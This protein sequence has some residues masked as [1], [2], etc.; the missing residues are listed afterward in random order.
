MSA[1]QTPDHVR[2][3]SSLFY[4]TWQRVLLAGLACVLA[5]VLL[6][7]FFVGFPGGDPPLPLSDE[8]ASP[9][10][11]PAGDVLVRRYAP[12]GEGA[13]PASRGSA[14]GGVLAGFFA[15]RGGGGLRAAGA[16]A[17]GAGG[18]VVPAFCD[19]PHRVYYLDEW[20]LAVL[21]SAEYPRAAGGG[22]A[23]C[24]WRERTVCE[25]PFRMCTYARDVDT[26]ISKAVQVDGWWNAAKLRQLEKALPLLTAGGGDAPEKAAPRGSPG[27]APAPA[28]TLFID[29]GANIGFYSLMAAARGYDVLAVEPSAASLQRL[30][31]SVE[32][33]PGLTAAASGSDLA[34]EAPGAARGR[35]GG[36]GGSGGGGDVRAAT[37]LAM[38]N[39]AADVYGS[40]FLHYVADNP[41]ASFVNGEATPLAVTTVF[42]DDLLADGFRDASAGRARPAA[43]AAPAIDPRSVRAVKISAEAMDARVLH[44]ARRLLGLGE[45]P[46]VILVYNADHVARAGCKPT[47]LARAMF[48]AGYRLRHAGV[49]I[50]RELEL[51]RFLKKVSG[52]STELVFVRH[53]GNGR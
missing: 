40:A 14:G 15:R 2:C 37:V 6:T 31:L 10:A 22:A 27:P 45:V 53:A 5:C 13:R 32:A 38:Q 25:R 4:A 50:D 30:L 33:T 51:A 1:Y 44:G 36:G 9:A 3:G 47:D 23:L 46:F 24:E 11:A 43:A 26:Q 8:P 19:A 34:A 35:G 49:F 16:G 21:G 20:H 28:R 18:G 39:A 48:A 29:V 41:G 7:T 42:L 12:P 17:A 52:F